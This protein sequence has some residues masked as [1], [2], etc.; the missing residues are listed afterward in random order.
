MWSEDV[1]DFILK[2]LVNILEIALVIIATIFLLVIFKRLVYKAFHI[3]KD[4]DEMDDRTKQ[5]ATVV[6]LFVTICQYAT[7]F[8]VI[9]A[10]IYKLSNYNFQTLITIF[11]GTGLTLGIIGR[12][13]ILDF[14]NGLLIVTERQFIVGD[15]IEVGT[16]K[17]VVVKIGIR[18]TEI[19]QADGSYATISNR[20]IDRVINY[21]NIK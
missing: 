7:W 6:K 10:I 13:I 19:I 14:I 3:N 9:L 16:I 15:T 1:W 20:V 8:G 17:G 5:V 12:E 2:N 18:T 11:T 4:V 21:T